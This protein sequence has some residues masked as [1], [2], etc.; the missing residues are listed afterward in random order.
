MRLRE[1]LADLP[2]YVPGKLIPGYLK[3]ASNE[4]PF[5]PGPRAIEAIRGA[6]SD[7]HIYPDGAAPELKA[8]LGV[9]WK[10]PPEAFVLGN[11]S[12]E[13]LTL[14][15]GAYFRPGDNAVTSEHTFS[16][17]DFSVRLFGATMRRA[18]QKD[19]VLDL[20]AILSLVDSRTRAVFLCNPNNPTGTAFSQ[21]ALKAFLDKLPSEV[22]VVL[23]EAYAE[24][25][26]APDFPNSRDLLDD[27]PNLFVSR[28][29]SKV[30]GLASMRVGYGVASPAIIADLQVVRQPFNVGTLSQA[31]AT[32]A[33]GDREFFEKTLTNNRRERQRLTQ[34]LVEQGFRVLPSQANFIA[35]QTPCGGQKVFELIRDEGIT[36]RPLGSF[37]LPDWVRI[38]VGTPEQNALFLGAWS[39]AKKKF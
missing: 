29:F 30:Y 21:S 18:P 4:N 25:A 9:Q 24:F 22:L 20:E 6:V 14:V 10:L 8:A 16:A 2:P 35:V 7:V 39:R 38:T 33:L 34:A 37:G 15:A 19:Y 36:I 3:L 23:D 17:Y 13:V 5:G 11:G 27:Y 26:D 12:D 1:D 32:A 31:A 28:T